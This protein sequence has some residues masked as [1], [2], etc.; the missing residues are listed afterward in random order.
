MC[1]C[2]CAYTQ[3]HFVFL[4]SYSKGG[5]LYNTYRLS[6]SLLFYLII[7]LGYNIQ[8]IDIFFIHFQLHTFLSSFFTQICF[9]QM[10]FRWFSYFAFANNDKM[11]N[12]SHIL[13]FSF[14]GLFQDEF[15]EAELL[16]L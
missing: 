7:H 11:N 9:P 4:L 6:C 2:L 14:G 3:P 1:M 8:F 15:L 12:L 10:T 13:V 5:L 16:L